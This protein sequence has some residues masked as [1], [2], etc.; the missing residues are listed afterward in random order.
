MANTPSRHAGR[1]DERAVANRDAPGH[2]VDMPAPEDLSEEAT[3]VWE[4]VV[5]TLAEM[6][7]LVESDGHLLRE[8]VGSLALARRYRA[9]ELRLL[10]KGTVT[11]YDR[12]GNAY[13]VS[14]AG[15]KS[16]KRVRK[17]RADAMNEVM[18][19]GPH[20]GLTPKSRIGM[21]LMQLEG[22]TLLDA[23]EGLEDR[24]DAPPSS[25]A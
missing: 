3:E 16:V 25:D 23:L 8:L 9:E 18:R 1:T 5:P 17:A 15:S 4:D 12:N 10:D 20:F 14:A 7:A 11:E 13:T 21:G 22:Q 24:G 19:L 2:N 6:G